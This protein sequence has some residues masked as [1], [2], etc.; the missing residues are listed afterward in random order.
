MVQNGAWWEQTQRKEILASHCHLYKQTFSVI[1]MN[2][3]MSQY[4]EC[5]QQT[6][7]T[8]GR[9]CCLEFAS[10]I[11]SNC[12]H[13][14]LK[15]RNMQAGVLILFFPSMYMTVNSFPA[16]GIL[17]ECFMVWQWKHD[18]MDTVYHSIDHSFCV[19]TL[20]SAWLSAEDIRCRCCYRTV[21]C[22]TSEAA[23]GFETNSFAL[24]DQLKL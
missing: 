15:S 3:K 9:R 11:K 5:L 4:V 2:S 22:D 19:L 10:E 18:Q 6:L 16:S 8:W 12:H 20:W 7:N 14:V 1:G 17:K 21:H 23:R 24:Q 13:Y